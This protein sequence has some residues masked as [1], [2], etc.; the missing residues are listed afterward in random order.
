MLDLEAGE[1][2]PRSPEKG[3]NEEGGLLSLLAG[4]LGPFPLPNQNKFGEHSL[5]QWPV[6][7]ALSV[8][9]PCTRSL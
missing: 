8:E 7:G 6:S 3:S 1:E 9:G 5:S 2:I 4:L